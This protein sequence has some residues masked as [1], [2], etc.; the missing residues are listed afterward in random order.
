[1]HA[2]QALNNET[3]SVTQRCQGFW[4]RPMPLE[5]SAGLTNKK[6][7]HKAAFTLTGGAGG[8]RTRGGFYPTHAF[9]ACDLNHS[10]TAPEGAILPCIHPS[11]L[12]VGCS[13]QLGLTEPAAPRPKQSTFLMPSIYPYTLIAVHSQTTRLQVKTL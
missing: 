4:F 6:K 2:A 9:Q 12:I 13:M 8:I 11:F 7:P 1:M 5:F 10:S 3:G